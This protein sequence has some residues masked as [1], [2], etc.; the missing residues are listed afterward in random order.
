M[1][2]HTSRDA[3]LVRQNAPTGVETTPP[4]ADVANG[5]GPT[6]PA[7]GP[8]HTPPDHPTPG[9]IDA[10]RPLEARTKARS[11]MWLVLLGI[12]TPLT[13]GAFLLFGWWGML[14]LPAALVPI[15]MYRLLTAD[16]IEQAS[17]DR[18]TDSPG[19]DARSS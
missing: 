11:I 16:A 9:P 12:V 5:P 1:S 6:P 18:H 10:P 14:A 19:S 7:P 2:N 13:I 8:D 4:L 17:S 3:I 15:G